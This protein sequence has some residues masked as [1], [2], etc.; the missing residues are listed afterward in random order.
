MAI[1]NRD[2]LASQGDIA[3]RK[4]LL[5]IADTALGAL[6]VSHVIRAL[7]RVE[8][9]ALLV[10]NRR[11]QLGSGRRLFVVGAG[12]AANAM[13]RAVEE[14]LGDRI[15]QGLAIVKRLEPGDELRRIQLTEGGHPLPNAAGLAASRRIL[16][17]V[18]GATRDD[19]FISLISGGSSAL[20]S[21]PLPG[22]TLQ[23]EQD[24]TA[25]LLKS[26]ARILEINAVRRHISAVN[27]GRLAERIEAKGAELINLIISD[28]VGREPA[29]RPEEPTDF[30][31]TPVAPDGTT[32]RDAR[33]VLDRYRLW[34]Q[35]PR[36]I[37]EFLK[38]HGA[39][40]E[41]P[42]AFGPRVQHFVL[43]RPGNAC[44]AAREAAQAAGLSACVLTSQLEGESREAGSFL[45]C[46]AKE[47]ALNGRPLPPPC[48]LI[49]GGETTTKIEGQ[50]GMGGPSQELALGFALE[51]AGMSGL[52]IGAIDTDG[53]DGPTE[54]AGG[55][56]DGTSVERARLRGLNVYD[57]LRAHD[58]STLLSAIGDEVITGNTGTNLCDLNVI[59]VS[60]G[61]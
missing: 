54:I 29:L 2:R 35:A 51:V 16:Q 14:I 49:A 18:E 9:S 38:S 25:A 7:L 36:S 30:F 61:A 39:R 23:D 5:Q 11:Y 26:S 44:E 32:L 59:Y 56:A 40:Q 45:A 19:L 22:I 6:D 3:A 1:R 28:S 17:L 55:L 57:L 52:C 27:G 37:V 21:C 48:I 12:K 34:E 15:T 33:D 8:G 46:I 10:G 50:A 42:K 20:M 4:A 60:G 53:T 58:S 13:A 47:V 24:V 41:T 31:G 43:Q